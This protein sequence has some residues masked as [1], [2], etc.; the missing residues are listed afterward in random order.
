[1]NKIKSKYGQGIIYALISYFSWGMFPLFWKM[2]S[3]IP[4]LNVLA[5]RMLWSCFFLLLVALISKSKKIILYISQPKLFIRLGLAG[6]IIA[7][8][9]GVYIY[10]VETNHIVEASLG[11]YINPLFNVLLGVFF[12]KEKLSRSQQLAVLSAFIGVGY[13]TFDY[14]KLPWISIVLALSFSFYGLLKKK[15]NLDSMPAL[16]VETLVVMPFALGFLFYSGASDNYP[17]FPSS[18]FLTL[19]LIFGGVITIAPLYWFGKAAQKIPLST[20]GFIQYVTP[21]IQLLIGVFLYN[22]Q[23]TKAHLVCFCFVWTGLFIYTIS[24]VNKTIKNYKKAQS[25]QM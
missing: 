15:V 18:I 7:L 6:C 14:G 4:A 5:H 16:T 23:F 3:S 10:A 13:I 24:L 2:L 1:M 21:T 8:N 17:F 20:L 9:W 22:E 12:L 19:L 11:Y 25:V